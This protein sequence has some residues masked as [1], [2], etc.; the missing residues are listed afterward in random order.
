MKT[1]ALYRGPREDRMPDQ[2]PS[3]RRLRRAAIIIIVL[4]LAIVATIFVTF[5]ISHYRAM[6]N[7]VEAQ[8]RVAPGS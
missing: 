2:K 4:V 1:S 8:N 3:D 5:N 7:E 6:E